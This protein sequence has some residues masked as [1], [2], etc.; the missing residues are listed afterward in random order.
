VKPLEEFT[1]FRCNK[2]GKKMYLKHAVCPACKGRDF[3]HVNIQGPGNVLTY[4][5]LYA[6]P[7]GIDEMPLVLGIIE[8][9][10]KVAL[11][12]QITTQDVKIG[13]KVQ[14]V[15]GKIRKMQG[16]DVFGFKFEVV[17]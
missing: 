8:F 2:C 9:E 4:T 6:T 11:T 5:K 15:W 7:E 17:R 10:D 12:G 3:E 13:D 14:P 16:K 1:C